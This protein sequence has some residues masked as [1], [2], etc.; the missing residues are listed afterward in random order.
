MK[1]HMRKIF[2]LGRLLLVLALLLQISGDAFAHVWTDKPDYAPG[3]TVT[4]SGN[5]DNMQNGQQ[6]DT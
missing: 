1:S 6:L 2:V 3:E 5:G 4:F